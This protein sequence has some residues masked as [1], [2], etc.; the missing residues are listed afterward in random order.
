MRVTM[1]DMVALCELHDNDYGN[2][3]APIPLC[4]S[5]GGPK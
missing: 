3:I 4:V 5:G 2:S 1:I